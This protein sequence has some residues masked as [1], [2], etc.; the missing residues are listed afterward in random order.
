MNDEYTKP[1]SRFPRKMLI[2]TG[3]ISIILFVLH[4]QAFY[5][6]EK[7]GLDPG[8]IWLLTMLLGMITLMMWCFWALFWGK[9]RI[10]GLLLFLIPVGFFTL[11]YPN[12]SGD[13]GLTGFKPRFWS[14]SV[15][16]VKRIDSGI[17]DVDVKTTTPN[18]FAQF[19]GPNRNAQL[20]TVKLNDSWET[21][22]ELLWKIDIGEGWSGFVVVNGN[23]IT[24]EQRGAQECVT[25]YD[26]ETGELLWIN[27]NARRH[28]D[29]AAM[30]KVGP[31]AT[32]AVDDGLVYVTSGTGVL[33]CL[34]GATGDTVWTA[35][36][37]KLVGIKQ[38][39][40]QNSMGLD[41]STENSRMAWGRSGSP[42]VFDDI[43]VVPAGGV[44]G[45]SGEDN[46]TAT[47]IAFDKKTGEEKWRGGNRMISYGSP[48][49]ATLGG[50]RQIL[51]VAENCGVGHDAET[52]EELW[53]HERSG[54]SNA[55][56]N[57]SQVTYVGTDKEGAAH[58]LLSKGYSMG[59]EEIKVTQADGGW[60]VQS[61]SKNP[62]VLKTKF[63][64]PVILSDGNSP[65]SK[66]AFSLSDGYLESA[67]VFG[68]SKADPSLTRKWKQRGRFGNGQILL[69]GDKLLVHSETGTLFLV[70]ANPEEYVELGSVDTIK[71]ICW[72]TIC[73]YGD[74]VVVRSEIEAACFRLPA[75]AQ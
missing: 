29:L 32:P 60:T 42:L 39:I 49:L 16:Y 22:P 19:L 7:F 34:D 27:K 47:L 67:T 33:D 46:K 12:L 50:K 21:P 71:G 17:V 20:E 14:R 28:E 40:T 37:P 56:A 25:C 64:N 6:N 55:D 59:G 10:L 75:V 30:G 4:W 26:V 2:W 24:Q 45:A 44:D 31:R 9:Q 69:V 65:N 70:E 1:K 68:H 3:L 38:V 35:D 13:V 73:L 52:G 5:F 72:N 58:L 66:F 62:R 74:L 48:T 51:L 61:L 54:K 15:D 63:T 18:D 8:I 23:A 57:C 41:Y 53:S 43:V 11:Y 36:V